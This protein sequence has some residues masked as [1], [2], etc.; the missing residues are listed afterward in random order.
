[1]TEYLGR[2]LTDEEMDLISTMSRAESLIYMM[3]CN[4]SFREVIISLAKLH[5]KECQELKLIH[6]KELQ[7][8][9]EIHQNSIAALNLAQAKALNILSIT[10]QKERDLMN[11]AFGVEMKKLSEN[12]KKLLEM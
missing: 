7:S 6:Q 3:E 12:T 10:L 11:K 1:M 2:S 9:R 4:K 5:Q 8:M